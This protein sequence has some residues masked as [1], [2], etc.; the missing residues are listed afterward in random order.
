MLHRLLPVIDPRLYTAPIHEAGATVSVRYL[1]TA[2]FVAQA[3]TVVS[4]LCTGQGGLE[5][6]AEKPSSHGVEM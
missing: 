1:G 6:S 3:P 5:E 4:A 2:G